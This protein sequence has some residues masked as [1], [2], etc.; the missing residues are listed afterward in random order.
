MK[1]LL[2]W[3][4]GGL[5]GWQGAAYAA[6]PDKPIT[7]I[8]PFAVGSATDNIA[9]ALA[10]KLSPELK[11][12]IVVENRA[13]ANG[14]IGTATGAKADNDGYTVTAVTGTTIAQN[15]WMFKRLNYDPLKDFQAIGRLGGFSLAVVV[16][17]DSPYNT[18]DD[19]LKAIRQ[20]TGEISYATAYGMQTVCG[21]MVAH[22]AEGQVLSVP[23]KS[24]PQ[25]I[26]DLMGGT[27]TFVCA[28]LA[29][30]LSGITS[31]KIKALTVLVPEGSRY[32][33]GVEPVQKSWPEFPIMQSWVGLVAPKGIA[34]DRLKI[35]SDAVRT[36]A[37]TPEFAQSLA[38]V[39]FEPTPMDASS[40]DRYMKDEYQRWETLIKQA[41]IEPQ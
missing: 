2:Y 32:L 6:Y 14:L 8:V 38:A 22:D 26:V 17:G 27:L 7:L 31:K 30:G 11:V 33:P 3:I 40:F 9:R 4:L 12:P 18:Y 24:S 35:L 15:P 1:R 25:A 41:G 23:Y 36:V 29:T 10:A 13:G 39:G 5:V 37:Q 28:D 21:E 34:P 16:R 19:L 20:G